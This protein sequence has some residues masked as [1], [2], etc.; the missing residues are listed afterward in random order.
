MLFRDADWRFGQ[1]ISPFQYVGKAA[2]MTAITRQHWP[3][4][5]CFVK[6]YH[7]IVFDGFCFLLGG[8]CAQPLDHVDAFGH[9]SNGWHEHSR[10]CQWCI[11]SSWRSWRIGRSFS[12]LAG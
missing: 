6:N 8:G 10:F 5:I 4:P 3:S 12:R 9:G 7:R 1:A 11:V 2:E